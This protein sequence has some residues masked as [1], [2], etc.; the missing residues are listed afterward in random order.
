M[1]KA[2]IA[3]LLILAFTVLMASCD[4]SVDCGPDE[5]NIPTPSNSTVT[6]SD[7]SNDKE[8]VNDETVSSSTIVS[9]NDDENKD[10]TNSSDNSSNDD[11]TNSSGNSSN[12]DTVSSDTTVSS[13]IGNKDPEP[14]PKPDVEPENV[15]IDI[16]VNGYS[17]YIV[18]YDDSDIRVSNFA[19]KLVDYINNTLD[20]FIEPVPYSLYVEA[21]KCIYIGDFRETKWVKA[22]LNEQNDFG[23][24]I[25][26]D[27][28]VL[29]ATN[30]RLYDYL[31]DILVSEI[32]ALVR[33]GNWS[34]E[35]KKDF[36]YHKS[37][38]KDQSYVDYVINKKGGL[39]QDVLFSFFDKCI[40]EAHD[41]TIIPYRMYVPYDYDAAKE[42]PILT[43][44]HGA[45]ERG[46]DNTSQ[47]SNMVYPMFCNENT[48][49][50]DSIVICPQCPSYPEQWVD[51]PWANGNYSVENVPESNELKAVLEILDYLD[52]K[53]SID[54]DRYYLAGLSMGGFGV[55]DLLMRHSEKFA[56]AVPLCGGADYTQADK[57]VNMPI[58]T[59]HGTND[60]SVP[61]SGTRQ[62]VEAL[63]ELG[64][65]AL[66]YEELQ[67]YGH[68]VWGYAADK[69]EIWTWLFDQVRQ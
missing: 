58:Y 13:S 67:G 18:V 30:N 64:S 40:F 26:G 66:K 16:A 6:S 20:I 4:K 33:N 39:T 23:A 69:D 41:G 19:I 54:D 49:L 22:R 51:T 29:C 5:E 63:K 44:L 3:L 43:I 35:P 52:R 50:W 62:M 28:Y 27:D 34:T 60:T 24:C 36:I 9:S 38:H 48:P 2:I 37:S 56:G 61:I 21:G 8:D 53:Y 46:N 1:K 42:Y 10:T 47:M 59:I 14:E 31:Y 65:T 11:T 57:L 15:P 45:G 12:D 32:L 7:L 17:A 68:N 55:W 25:S